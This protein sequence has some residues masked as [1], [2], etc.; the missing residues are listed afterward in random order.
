[1]L[2]VALF[3]L[4]IASLYMTIKLFGWYVN[5]APLGLTAITI[6]SLHALFG[7]AEREAD[8]NETKDSAQWASNV[9]VSKEAEP[10][11]AKSDK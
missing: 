11:A 2:V 9:P 3:A 8:P 4:A 10:K 7:R 1:M 5:P 6:K